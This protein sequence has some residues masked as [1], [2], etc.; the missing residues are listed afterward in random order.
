MLGLFHDYR[1]RRYR[2]SAGMGGAQATMDIY[3]FPVA[4]E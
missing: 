3:E 4:I 2:P 1:R